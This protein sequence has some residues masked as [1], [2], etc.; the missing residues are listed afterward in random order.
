MKSNTEAHF[1]RFLF[2]TAVASSLLV[3]IPSFANTHDDTNQFLVLQPQKSGTVSRS[4]AEIA[5]G[6]V[7]KHVV[8]INLRALRDGSSV[9]SVT[10]AHGQSVEESFEEGFVMQLPGGPEVTL[11]TKRVHSYIDSVETVSGTVKD[12]DSGYFTLSIED[13]KVYGQVN[14]EFFAYDI[15]FDEAVGQHVLAEIDQAMVPKHAPEPLRENTE[16]QTRQKIAAIPAMLSS[17]T[18]G[19]VRVLILHASDVPNVTVLASNIISSINDTFFGGGMD[20]DLHVTLAGLRNLND[21]L[22]G[23]CNPEMLELMTDEDPPFT[24]LANWKSVD[25]ADVVLTIATTDN[26]E[27]ACGEDGRIGGRASALLDGE[28]PYAVAMNTFAV[29]DFTAAHELG[30][31]FGGGH[32]DWTVDDLEFYSQDAAPYSRGLIAGDGEWQTIMG[33]Y[34]RN[35]CNFSP[36]LPNPDCVRIPFWSDP[37]KYY[38]G[39]SRG[40]PFSAN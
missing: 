10:D 31:V 6:V 29:G 18:N 26:A 14:I 2:S 19:T 21:D 1:H 20:P 37:S 8:D 9:K 12:V 11:I 13:G 39:E 4:S 36:T 15:R 27:T 40:V 33:G 22:D 28:A 7:G 25:H 17:T 23:V 35:G 32:S 24:A 5:R 34:N 30:H 16:D 38:D 3:S